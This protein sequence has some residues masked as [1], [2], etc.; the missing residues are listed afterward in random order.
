MLHRK[1]KY[2]LRQGALLSKPPACPISVLPHSPFS[3][4]TMPACQPGHQSSSYLS[5]QL[6][7]EKPC[8]LIL[9]DMSFYLHIPSQPIPVDNMDIPPP[10]LIPPQICPCSKTMEGSNRQHGHRRRRMPSDRLCPGEV[11][12]WAVR[13][14]YHN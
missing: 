3:I 6:A 4:P 11:A 14:S 12:N 10:L 1:F 9:P 7:P 5:Q 13:A 2:N 8:S